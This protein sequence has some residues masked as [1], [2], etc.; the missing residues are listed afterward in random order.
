MQESAVED[1]ELNVTLDGGQESETDEQAVSAEQETAQE[2]SATSEQEKP[3]KRN[4]LQERFSELTAQR[5]ELRRRAE[6]A[7]AKAQQ[8]EEQQHQDPNE[9]QMVQQLQYLASQ[10]PNIDSFDTHTEYEQAY[11][12]WMATGMQLNNQL[13]GY[14]QYR[15]TE[16]QRQQQE[17]AAMRQAQERQQATEIEKVQA[18]IASKEDWYD[19]VTNPEVPSV[20]AASPAAYAAMMESDYFADITYHL[21]K[22]PS[23]VKKLEGMSPVRAVKAIAELERKI[24]QRPQPTTVNQP[25]SDLP[26]RGG[27][28]DPN[29]M[30]IEEW[31]A[32]RNEQIQ[33]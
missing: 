14:R 32:W 23:E 25:P 29:K 22:H 13:Q 8:L 17:Q 30:S 16:R 10:K 27:P 11:E 26:S 12:R 3:E 4:R 28:R 9:V 24:A 21:A 15:D 7:E 33:G 5:E 6:E 19:V 31:M 20:K 1:L 18:A 2:E